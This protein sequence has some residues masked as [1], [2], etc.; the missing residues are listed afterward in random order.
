[1]L[2]KLAEFL[3]TFFYFG[4]SPVAPGTIG[5][6][7]ALVLIS[8]LIWVP[9][10]FWCV[11]AFVVATTVGFVF[12]PFYLN[13]KTDDLQE[14]V[15]DEASGL[16][17]TILIAML[18]VRFLGLRVNWYI[19][20]VLC[21]LLFRVFDITKPWLIGW[22]DRHLKGAVGIMMDDIV[23]GAFAGVIMLLLLVIYKYCLL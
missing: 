1:M 3:C 9:S 7:A 4:T 22:C 2:K 21:F 10:I 8:P 17:F 5:S 19:T 13:G 12:T 18:C 11:F 23:A 6:I 20:F 16:Y 15:I 14:I